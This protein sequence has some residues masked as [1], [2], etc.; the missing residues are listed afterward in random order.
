RFVVR[1]LVLKK[2]KKR[3]KVPTTNQVRSEDFSPQE[4]QKKGLQSLLQTIMIKSDSGALVRRRPKNLI[5]M[6]LQA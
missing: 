1:T 6:A 2:S 5:W 4:T 3:T